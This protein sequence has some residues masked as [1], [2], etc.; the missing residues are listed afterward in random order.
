[1]NIR[2]DFCGACAALPLVFASAGGAALSAKG[3]FGSKIFFW[4]MIFTVISIVATIYYFK[5]KNCKTCK[6]R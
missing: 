6:P 4:S 5:K 2:E 3:I 1:M